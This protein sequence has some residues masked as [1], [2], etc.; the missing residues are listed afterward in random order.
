MKR[1]SYTYE[2]AI[3]EAQLSLIHPKTLLFDIET[4]GLSSKTSQIYCI[5][6]AYYIENSLELVQLFAESK[7]DELQLLS[8]FL[9]ILPHYNN[10]ISYNGR[11]F[12]LRYLQE[13][14]KHYQLDPSPLELAHVDLYRLYTPFKKLLG[15]QDQKQKTLEQLLDTDRKDEYNGGE[16]IKIYRKYLKFPEEE[17]LE[18]LLLHN[19]EDVYGLFL[20]CKLH[21]LCSLFSGEWKLGKIEYEEDGKTSLVFYLNL[22]EPL[23]VTISY[24]ADKIFLYARSNTVVLKVPVLETTMRYYYDNY[25]DYYYFPEE[26]MAIH[27]MLAKYAAS[28]HKVKAT[29]KTAYTWQAG[30]FI[31]VYGDF[32]TE[33]LKVFYYDDAKKEP[34]ILHDDSFFEEFTMAYCESVLNYILKH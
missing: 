28:D 26:D 23:P 3:N 7:E 14:C 34:Y 22:L 6:F 2:I 30:S 15:L 27:K 17:K 20:L 19:R 29:A 12:D 10:L 24:Y 32:K 21:S 31:P 1:F 16:L 9:E 5:G 18:L 4:T 11:T 25:K 8:S 33:N 13:K